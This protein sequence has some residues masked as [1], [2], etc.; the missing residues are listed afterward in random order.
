[1]RFR[2]NVDA[3]RRAQLK[4]SPRLVKVATVLVTDQGTQASYNQYEDILAH[5][6]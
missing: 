2:I 4:I 1:V 3:V 5:N 6:L